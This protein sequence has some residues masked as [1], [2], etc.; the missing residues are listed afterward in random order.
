MLG[1]RAGPSR[2]DGKTI[3]PLERYGV[4]VMSIGFLVDEE[5]PMVWRGPMVT[6][7]LSSC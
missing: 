3:E 2:A 7:A 6:Q 5:Q 1:S 4:K